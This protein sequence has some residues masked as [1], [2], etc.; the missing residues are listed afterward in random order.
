MVSPGFKLVDYSWGYGGPD[1]L[2]PSLFR[3][4][5]VARTTTPN[6]SPY[7]VPLLAETD[8][9]LLDGTLPAGT[10]S[11]LLAY[12]GAD[13]LVSRYDT[14]GSVALAE[15]AEL[16]LAVDSGLRGVGGFGPAVGVLRH[17]VVVRAGSTPQE[18]ARPGR[19]ALLLDGDGAALPDLQAAGLLDGAPALLPTSGLSPASVERAVEDGARYVV[20]DTNARRQRSPE[21]QNLTGPLLAGDDPAGLGTATGATDDQTVAEVVGGARLAV[22]GR[23]ILFGPRPESDPALAFDG[24]RSSAWRFGNFGTGV[25]NAL[26][27]ELDRPIQVPNITIWAT[28][29]TGVRATRVRVTASG[30]GGTVERML[31]LSE[32]ASFPATAELGATGVSR[33]RIEIA[34]VSGV[35]GGTLGLSEVA[36][37]GVELRRTARVPTRVPDLMQSWTGSAAAALESAPVDI[38][39][40]RRA[41]SVDGS[42]IEEPALDRLVRT[43]LARTFTASGT[44]RI[45]PTAADASIDVVSGV[46]RDLSVET[47]SR[48]AGSLSARGAGAIDGTRLAPDLA[49]AWSPQEPVVGEWILAR[50]PARTLDELTVTQPE[51]GA[52]A[53]RILVSVDD[54][55]PFEARLGAGVSTIRLTRPVPAT[56][57]R[58][59]IAE[60]TGS[61]PVRVLDLGLDR[62]A[63]PA[64]PPDCIEVATVDGVPVK[65]RIGD[66]TEDFLA[67][68]P[69]PFSGC[70][71]G[72]DLAAG[73]HRIRSSGPYLVD[74]LHL[75]SGPERVAPASVTAEIVETSATR[76]VVRLGSGC[77]PCYVSSGQGYDARWQ[78]TIAGREAGRP[79]VVDGY[80]AGWRVDAEPGT[81]VV[82]EYGLRT[83]ALLAWLASAAALAGCGVLLARRRARAERGRGS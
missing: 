26:I 81:E 63:S 59:L 23:G 11:T 34:E 58:I 83:T 41:G 16:G 19:G 56:R 37:P 74:D 38:V 64:T 75:A 35:G 43:P 18:L 78:A 44:V 46:R 72:P 47:S 65:G 62:G 10:M 12:T 25:G 53:T 55:A 45:S 50:F 69:V 14:L 30:P 80:A 22:E 42:S 82:M 33:I 29:D 52:L 67:G 31:A 32:W 2:G 6:G 79:L 76:R 1:D 21:A 60:R 17:T 77:R 24:D 73:P 7:A 39:L 70:D 13:R 51:T 68:L 15:R 71:S 28:N 61:G 48:L 4:E 49:T 8:S 5:S 9:R 40:R 54:G 3:R 66:R 27:V 57:V 36:I 20:T